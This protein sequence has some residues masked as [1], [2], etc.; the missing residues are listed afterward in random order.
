MIDLFVGSIGAFRR[1]TWMRVGELFS[2]DGWE[3][4]DHRPVTLVL[5]AEV[6]D[7][8]GAAGPPRRRR[9]VFDA[10]R[11]RDYA[12]YFAEGSHA[13]SVLSQIAGDLQNG[14]CDSTAA[15]DR[16]GSLLQK[17]MT[18]AFAG[19]RPAGMRPGEGII[20]WN[21]DCQQARQHMLVARA[22]LGAGRVLNKSGPLWVAFCEARSAFN[23]AKRLARA[24]Y[25]EER[26]R[27]FVTKCRYDQRAL[28]RALGGKLRERCAIEDIQVFQEHFASLLNAGVGETGVEG[29]H[30]LLNYITFLG[31]SLENGVWQAARAIADRKAQVASILDEPFSLEEVARA[32]GKLPNSKSPG[33]EK[34][35]SECYRYARVRTVDGEGR[36]GPEVNQ[37]VPVLHV[38]MEHIRTSG[39]FPQQFTK[40]VVTPLLKK[41]DP[42]VPGNYRGIA[43]GGALAKCYAAVLLDRLVRAGEQLALRHPS[44]AGFRRGFGTSHHLF[45]KQHLTTRHRRAGEKPLIVVQIDFEKAFDKVPREH[46][47]LRLQERGVGGP[48]LAALKKAYEKV[49]MVVKVNG[50]V[51]GEFESRQGVKQGCPLSTELFGLFIE[52]LADLI[53]VHDVVNARAR[54]HET[55]LVGGKCVS[56]LLYADDV[57]LLATSPERM[58]ELLNLVDLFC[59]AFGMRPN[60][61]KCERLVFACSDDLRSQISTACDAQLRLAGQAVPAKDS[62]RYLGLVYGPDRSFCACRQQL[63]DSA[64]S[65]LFALSAKLDKL[66]L[67][68]ADVR[69]RCFTTQVRAI[70][71]YG[72]QAW[73]PFVIAEALERASSGRRRDNN[74]LAEGL[75]EACLRDD[76]VQLQVIFMRQ[77]V[78]AARPAQ[79]LLFAEMAQLPLQYYMAKQVVGFWNRV[80]KQAGSLALAVLRQ[81]IHDALND[82]AGSGWGAAVLRLLTYLEIDI[83]SGMPQDVSGFDNRIDW[84]LSKPLPEGTIVTALRERLMSGWEHERLSVPPEAYPSDGKQPGVQ[85][86]KYKHWM[87]MPF[88]RAAAIMWPQHASVF[89]P[90]A[91]HRKLLQFR[92]CCW[93][94]AANRSRVGRVHVPRTERKC[95]CCVADGQIEDEKHVLMEC[96]AYSSIRADE[97]FP[98]FEGMEEAMRWDPP[99]L[100]KMLER[101]WAH[102]NSIVPFGR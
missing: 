102:R 43:V 12:R 77:I 46:M 61:S 93:A 40:T 91:A 63:C 26:M 39:D 49:S 66:K 67:F 90:R 85:M 73:G 41:G 31:D 6:C 52:T 98:Q 10:A 24:A 8:P 72:C 57:S 97:G 68:S 62:A 51:G 38:L 50:S 19:H 11:Y 94:V 16:I 78:G 15:V 70:L 30:R 100:A 44:Q 86:A 36:P 37:V 42:L 32:V 4:T 76:A 58:V 27:E 75:F 87:G 22:Q 28:W 83:W 7:R 80:R 2:L 17:V 69:M 92:L 29:A 82:P 54:K 81:E 79:R 14:V 23:R 13:M 88:A 64:R 95:P 25:D 55:P 18:R 84:L 48:M 74:N 1:A 101:I 45:V 47:W 3:P 20:W 33:L 35:P 21:A 5:D 60:V 99:R 9:V 71:L 53:D 89:I 96:P 34:V 65:A 59:V 56:I